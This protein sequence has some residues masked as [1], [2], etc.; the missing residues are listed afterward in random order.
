MALQQGTGY[1][2]PAKAMT[3][4]ALQERQKLAATAAQAATANVGSI[5]AD[6][7]SG[8]SYLANALSGGV[9][10]GRADRQEADARAQLS[11]IMAGIDPEKGATMAQ[12]AQMQ[13]LDPDFANKEYERAMAERAAVRAR[14]DQQAHDA[15]QQAALFGQQDKTQAAGFVHDDASAAAQRDAAAKL[16][17]DNDK[18]QA[19]EAVLADERS[20]QNAKDAAQVELD[21][22]DHTAKLDADKK[23][24]D[25][26]AENA[27]I[28][29]QVEARKEAALKLG[30]V[31]GTPEYQE[32][33]ATGDITR[34]ARVNP[35]DAFTPGQKAVDE[36]FAPEVLDWDTAG[37]A[38]ATKALTQVNQAIDILQ[39]KGPTGVL[40]GIA[41]QTLPEWMSKWANPDATVARD[42]IRETVQQTL[43]ATLGAQFTQQEGEGLMNR[44]FDINLDPKE[45]IRRGRLL[46]DQIKT[47]ATNKQ[48][49]V[50]YFKKNGSLQGYAGP[51][52]DLNSLVNIDLGDK[53]EPPADTTG[54]G[55]APAFDPAQDQEGDTG[56]DDAGK[57][58]V[59][60]NGA[61]VPA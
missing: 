53:K 8:V 60:R 29:P 45:N 43:R 58:W 44:A 19:A 34:P 11:S 49:M 21:K 41:D 14:E 1:R 50:D 22:L 47:I 15:A 23:V 54:T 56:T 18:R 6:P 55:G 27:N 28:G 20:D 2:D 7:L 42:A 35:A 12:I 4:K 39:T 59:V 38:N 17:E 16:A 5:T 40:A 57:K 9:Q 30:L 37:G 52:V 24:S 61:W 48:A 3:I 10:Q 25:L 36:K 46:L 26:A 51:A 13:Q 31:E 32:Y 33:T